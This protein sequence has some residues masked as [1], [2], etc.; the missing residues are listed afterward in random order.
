M[1]CGQGLLF[2][3]WVGLIQGSGL[4]ILCRDL[5]TRSGTGQ[6]GSRAALG[7]GKSRGGSLQG[8]RACLVCTRT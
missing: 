7:T 2:Q 6:R 1:G 4:G 8:E 5:I 3:A